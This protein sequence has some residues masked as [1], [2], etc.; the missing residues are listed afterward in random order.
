MPG[1]TAGTTTIAIEALTKLTRAGTVLK[2]TIDASAVRG[3]AEPEIVTVLAITEAGL[4][5][6]VMTGTG[7]KENDPRFEV[8]PRTVID[9]E[10]LTGDADTVY[11]LLG[12]WQIKREVLTPTESDK[13]VQEPLPPD[14]I[15]T[16]MFEITEPKSVPEIVMIV[17]APP[18]PGLT[19]V[20]VGTRM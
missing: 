15:V 12:N 19:E 7:T 3:N 4:K 5:I 10:T 16:A 13:T 11:P 2:S 9:R 14:A 17:P 6:P 18:P 1:K 20:I 8:A